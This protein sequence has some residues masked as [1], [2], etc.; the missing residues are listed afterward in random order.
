MKACMRISVWFWT[1]FGYFMEMKQGISKCFVS[2]YHPSPRV[3]LQENRRRAKEEI[4]N[5]EEEMSLAQQ[6]LLSRREEQERKNCNTG[7]VR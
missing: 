6:Q 1:Y 3:L 4:T 5:M 7:S 2:V